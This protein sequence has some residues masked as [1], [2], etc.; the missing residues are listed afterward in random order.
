MPD[1]E[2]A[3]DHLIA[4][5]PSS[6]PR[7]A[8]ILFQETGIGGKRRRIEPEHVHLFIQQIQDEL[9]SGPG[10]NVYPGDTGVNSTVTTRVFIIGAHLSFQ[11]L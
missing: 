2:L 7:G 5:T 4:M 1:T 8:H 11:C 6:C 10:A 9:L 3:V